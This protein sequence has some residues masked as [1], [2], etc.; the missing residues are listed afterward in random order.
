MLAA[1]SRDDR[2]AGNQALTAAGGWTLV[3]YDSSVVM[4]VGQ[5]DCGKMTA[6]LRGA[7]DAFPHLPQVV[8][9]IYIHY[10]AGF[11]TGS[12][13]YS[14]QVQRGNPNVGLNTSPEAVL[15]ALKQYCEQ[16]PLDKVAVALADVYR[17]LEAQ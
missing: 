6:D 7:G 13:F 14:T 15:E 5:N 10:A 17:Q 8:S 1:C 12:N 4:G 3:N 9:A 2:T 16:H 11:V